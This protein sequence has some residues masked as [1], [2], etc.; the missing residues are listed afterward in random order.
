MHIDFIELFCYN[1]YLIGKIFC[2]FFHAHFIRFF[3]FRETLRQRGARR[4]CFAYALRRRSALEPGMASLRMSHHVRWTFCWSPKRRPLFSSRDPT[5]HHTHRR[6]HPQHA[7]LPPTKGLVHVQ[8]VQEEQDSNQDPA[9]GR[10]SE[11]HEP[12]WFT[13]GGSWT[14]QPQRQAPDPRPLPPRRAAQ[15]RRDEGLHRQREGS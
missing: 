15:G 4:G 14:V 7:L 9:F 13:R 6:H 1:I 12:A 5:C 2:V 10:G 11:R 8:H 3:E